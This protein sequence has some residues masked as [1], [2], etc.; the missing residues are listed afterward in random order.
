YQSY[1][2]EAE[3]LYQ[4][5]GLRGSDPLEP[6]SALPYPCPPVSHEPRIQEIYDELKAG[7]YHP[8][9]CPVGIKLNEQTRWRSQCIRCDTCDGYPCLVEAKSD[10]DNNCIRPILERENVTLLTGAYVSRLLT[11]AAGNEITGVHVEF[12]DGQRLE[13]YSASIV[14]VACGAINSA[15]LLLRS[16]NSAQ[17]AGLANS[18]DLVGRNFMFH[19]AAIVLSIG[20]KPN[21]SKYMKT[22]AV[23][24]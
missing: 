13:T 7:G 9:P 4:A 12:E 19:K 8:F 2:D 16:A 1:Y 15:A 11:N 20:F 3:V 10:A 22:I 21:P 14:V 5:H 18:S 17:P 6:P 24:D 23:H